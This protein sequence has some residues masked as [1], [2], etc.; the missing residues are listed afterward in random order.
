MNGSTCR[1]CFVMSLFRPCP[2]SVLA[3]PHGQF[4]LHAHVFFFKGQ[5]YPFLTQQ[6]QQCSSH[7]Y[8]SCRTPSNHPSSRKLKKLISSS[9]IFII[10]Q[11]LKKL[12]L[13]SS[14]QIFNVF[15]PHFLPGFPPPPKPG[16]PGIPG[17]PGCPGRLLHRGDP[18]AQ[19]Q[20]LPGRRPGRR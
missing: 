17:H 2:T 15:F 8:S 13:S 5:C 7:P 6:Y 4:L 10:P 9:P 19:R 11:K 14:S 12:I 20:Q 16:G 18:A 1:F 3:I